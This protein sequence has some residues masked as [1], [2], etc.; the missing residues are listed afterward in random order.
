MTS[1]SFRTVRGGRPSDGAGRPAAAA[2]HGDPAGPAAVAPR[3]TSRPRAI[4]LT[5]ALAGAVGAAA[6]AYGGPLEHQQDGHQRSLDSDGQQVRFDGAGPERWA[7]RYR[8]VRRANVRLRALLAD[9]L[10]RIVYLV[11]SFR[12]IHGGEGSWSANTGNGYYGGLQFGAREWARF[13]GAF[14]PRAD[15]ATPSQQ[16]AAGIAYYMTGAG[17]RPWPNTARACGLLP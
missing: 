1:S 11:D 5:F 10:D 12:C 13:G 15:L 3:A 14:A 16:L 6:A 4:A 8:L 7:Y 2:R 9:R 17:F